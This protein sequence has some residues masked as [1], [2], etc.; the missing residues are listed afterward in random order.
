M[1]NFLNDKEKFEAIEPENYNGKVINIFDFDGTIFNSPNPSRTLW[2]NK[3]FGKLM[4]SPKQGGYGWYQNTRTLED[5]YIANSTFN[6]DVLDAIRLSNEDS[7]AVTVL[8]TGRT[9]DY[10]DMI[11]AIVMREGLEFDEYGFKPTGEKVTTFNFKTDFINDL[12]DKYDGIEVNLW[13]DRIKHVNRFREWLD[14]NDIPGKVIHINVPDGTIGDEKLER[15][16]VELLM[17]DIEKNPRGL[18]ENA[19][20]KPIYYAAFL[21]P[22]SHYELLNSIG[23]PN[24]WS[25]FAH[26]MTLLFGRNKNQVVEDYLK[27]NSGSD[28]ELIATHI[29]TSPDAMAVKISSDVPSDNETPHIT[30]AVPPGGKPFN[31]NKITDWVALD[32]PI[33]LK[34]NVGA[35]Y[36]K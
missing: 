4:S 5:K 28:V 12:I 7:D 21:Y 6:E 20:K 24:G 19:G 18:T 13:D 23:I 3:M 17:A 11:Q 2:D 36:G 16:L 27:E 22:E 33:K 15:E 29:G 10:S 1:K 30:L 14:L 32:T 34:A 9:T 25:K 35:F 8:L 31:S 26:H